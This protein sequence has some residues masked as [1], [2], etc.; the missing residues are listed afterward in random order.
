[1][2]PTTV[3][4][5]F[6]MIVGAFAAQ[7]ACAATTEFDVQVVGEPELEQ[8]SVLGTFQASMLVRL[9][10]PTEKGAHRAGKYLKTSLRILSQRLTFPHYF[11]ASINLTF[12]F[13]F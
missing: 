12:F 8:I 10:I 6:C 3:F 4:G 2:K 1:M 5:V 9:R 7:R 11:E 13:F